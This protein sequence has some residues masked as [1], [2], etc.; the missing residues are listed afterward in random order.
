MVEK[1]GVNRNQDDVQSNLKKANKRSLLILTISSS[2]FQLISCGVFTI[3][4]N[5]FSEFNIPNP[6]VFSLIVGY[7]TFVI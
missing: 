6:W 7:G 4:Y 1:N 2:V 5:V 3:F